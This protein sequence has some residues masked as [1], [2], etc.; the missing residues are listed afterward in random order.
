MQLSKTSNP[1]IAEHLYV[2]QCIDVHVHR[3]I[4]IPLA[5][6]P[7]GSTRGFAAPLSELMPLFSLNSATKDER[8]LDMFPEFLHTLAILAEQT[9]VPTSARHRTP[10]L[11]RTPYCPTPCHVL[12][13]FYRDKMSR[14]TRKTQSACPYR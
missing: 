1:P 4:S 12:P 9:T 8:F 3:S 2:L 5:I 13:T 10:F 14:S 6:L 11:L 7:L